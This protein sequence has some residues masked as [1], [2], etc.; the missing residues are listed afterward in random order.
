MMLWWQIV[1]VIFISLIVGLPLGVLLKYVIARIKKRPL[2]KR[3]EKIVIKPEQTNYITPELLEE[4]ERNLSIAGEP[5]ADKLVSF[6]T[7]IWKTGQDE[8]HRLE[9]DLREALVQA[10]MDINLA[11]VLVWLATDLGRRSENLNE[12]YRRLCREIAEKLNRVIS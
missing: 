12:H 2:L 9:A 3:D 8:I 11:N 5:Q 6:Q 7:E 10:Y 4:I 1:L